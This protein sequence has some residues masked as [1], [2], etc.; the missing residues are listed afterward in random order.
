MIKLQRWSQIWVLWPSEFGR[1]LSS[2]LGRSEREI[3]QRYEQGA[4]VNTPSSTS[5]L[6]GDLDV[7]HAHVGA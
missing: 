1:R 6:I 3:G 7:V 4:S 2:P 5:I